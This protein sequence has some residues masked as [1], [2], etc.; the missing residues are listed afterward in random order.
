VA[1]HAI[2]AGFIF[3]MAIHAA[4]H[5]DFFGLIHLLHLFDLTVTRNASRACAQMRAMTEEY[6]RWNLVDAPPFDLAV[7]F[8]IGGELLNFRTFGFDIG[9]ALHT[10]RRG[11]QAHSF[12]RIRILM[13]G[14]AFQP[15]RARVQFM[16]ESDRLLRARQWLLIGL[17][18]DSQNP[19][20]HNTTDFNKSLHI[21]FGAICQIAFLCL[22]NL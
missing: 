4:R 7:F 17:R 1:E 9:V 3:L 5:I 8:G 10:H 21:A 13:A 22:W 20:Q 11:R 14:G 18:G 2:R 15:L 12:S 6:I 16:T 19:K